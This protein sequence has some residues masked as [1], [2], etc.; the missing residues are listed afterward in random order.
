MRKQAKKSPTKSPKKQIPSSILELYSSIINIACVKL[1]INFLSINAMKSARIEYTAF[2]EFKKTEFLVS[3]MKAN[4]CA[5]T[6]ETN[7]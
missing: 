5:P 3:F 4:A 6:I 2:N 1:C 7:N